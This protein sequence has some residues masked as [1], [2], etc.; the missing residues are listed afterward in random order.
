MLALADYAIKVSGGCSPLIHVHVRIYLG[1]CPCVVKMWYMIYL[2]VT[3]AS[4]CTSQLQA[5]IVDNF[6]FFFF[7]QQ[8]TSIIY[9]LHTSNNL[10]R[11]LHLLP[12]WRRVQDT[13]FASVL[14]PPTMTLYCS[15]EYPLSLSLAMSPSSS[16]RAMSLPLPLTVMDPFFSRIAVFPSYNPL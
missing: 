6:F 13:V 4:K 9:Q 5:L 15:S 1:L 16:L 11:V 7:F 10:F 2:L 14:S 3:C 8:W 12:S